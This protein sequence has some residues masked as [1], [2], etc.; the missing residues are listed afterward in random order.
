MGG[1]FAPDPP[2]P[3]PAPVAVPVAAPDTTAADTQ[4]RLDAIDRNRRGLYGT[5]ATSDAGVLQSDSPA[6]TGKSLLGE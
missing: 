3:A 5:I 2:A 4:A 1:F 6:A